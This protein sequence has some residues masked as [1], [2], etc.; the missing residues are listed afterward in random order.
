[1]VAAAVL[2]VV[3]QKEHKLITDVKNG[4]SVQNVNA[5]LVTEYFSIFLKCNGNTAMPPQ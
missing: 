2:V 3:V 4:G 5:V 1:M